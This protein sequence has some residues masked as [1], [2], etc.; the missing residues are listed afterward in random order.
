MA[1]KEKAE[2]AE[3]FQCIGTNKVNGKPCS[4]QAKYP[5]PPA[6]PTHCKMHLDQCPQMK[7][8]GLELVKDIEA[9]D[10]SQSNIAELVGVP[11]AELNFDAKVLGE[12]KSV[13]ITLTRKIPYVSLVKTDAEL[14]HEAEMKELKDAHEKQL[15]ALQV[16]MAELQ[17]QQVAVVREASERSLASLKLFSEE[18]ASS[19]EEID[20]EEK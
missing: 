9:D 7:L 12:G 18:E 4:R 1:P 2:K 15:A 19:E 17:M 20:T 3:K 8:N 10:V 14:K 11:F 6:V 5:P 16:Q 13:V